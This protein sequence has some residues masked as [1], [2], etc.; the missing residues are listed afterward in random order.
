M[1][2]KRSGGRSNMT[3]DVA[4]EDRPELNRHGDSTT[5]HALPARRTEQHGFETNPLVS[6]SR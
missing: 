4:D 6:H 3:S 5:H 1:R 2:T